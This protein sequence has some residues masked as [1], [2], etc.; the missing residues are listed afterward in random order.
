[1]TTPSIRPYDPARD[2]E[3]GLDV[4]FKTV[5]SALNYEPTCTIG[6]YLWYMPYVALS[7]STCLVLSTDSP[8]S[9]VVGYIIGTSSTSSFVTRWRSEFVPTIDSAIVPPP[10]TPCSDPAM[11]TDDVKNF[12]A[13]V[14]NADCSM[15][16]PYPE[17]LAKY[18]AHVHIDILPEFQGK[19]Y[20][21]KL[22]EAWCEK[23][24]EEGA[25]GV[26]LDM[27]KDNVGGRKFYEKVGFGVCEQ[28]LDG[29]ESGETGVNGIVLTM[30]KKL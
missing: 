23:V 6:S 24:R 21:R 8:T 2:F 26:H 9:R 14:Y 27:V 25:T 12:R 16:L 17:V 5:N 11:Q 13:A 29:G 7:P 15:L 3:G 18:P 1:M 28:V 20:G 22:V 30:V 19:G 10:N 4:Y